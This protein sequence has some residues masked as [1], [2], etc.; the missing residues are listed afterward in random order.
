MTNVSHDAKSV[1]APDRRRALVG[2][3]AF[4]GVALVAFILAIAV[5]SVWIPP[6]DVL[7]ILFGGSSDRSG[8]EAIVRD[9]RLPRSITAALCGAGLG[10]AGVQMQ[11]LFRNPLAGPY[12]LGVSSGASLGVALV[13]LGSGTGGTAGFLAGLG[14][15][16]DLGVATASATGSI[17][18]LT[19][20]LAVSRRVESIA[21]VLI[22]GLMFGQ[23]VLAI[24]TVLIAGAQPERIQAYLMWGFGSFRGVSW[25]ELQILAPLIIIPGI[26][27]W[28]TSKHLNAMLLGERYAESLGVNVKSVRRITVV[29]AA[30]LAGSITAFAGPLAFIGVAVPHLARAVLGTVDHRYLLPASAAAGASV[31][32]IAEIGAQLP[33]KAGVLPLNAVTALIGAPVVVWVVVRNTRATAGF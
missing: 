30:L 13:V 3:G 27:V 28:F 11:T 18:V 26:A 1:Q 7:S 31:A 22:V 14:F 32:L 4:A 6:G 17:L 8:W 23:V 33:G 29:L 15:A 9:I 24:T 5:G 21:T 25:D 20:V 16:G 2:I 12:V 10:I 19:L